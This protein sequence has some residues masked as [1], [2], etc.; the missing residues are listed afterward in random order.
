M[1]RIGLL[2]LVCIGL[3]PAQDAPASAADLA[4]LV[5]EG[6]LLFAEFDDLGGVSDWMKNTSLGR[7]CSEPDVQ[8]FLKPFVDQIHSALDKIPANANPLAA[9]G[10]SW[11]DFQGIEIRRAGMA[12][13]DVQIP[14]GGMNA[15]PPKVDLVLSLGFRTGGNKA[16]EIT[17]KLHA[18]IQKRTGVAFVAT[19]VSGKTVYRAEQKG[20]EVFAYLDAQRF[21]ITMSRSRMEQTLDGLAGKSAG[22]SLAASA[23]FQKVIRQMGAERRGLLVYLDA[24]RVMALAKPHLPPEGLEAIRAMKI[25]ALEA[26][27]MADIPTGSRMRTEF[28]ISV[29]EPGGVWDLWKTYPIRHRFLK[30]APEDA[31]LYGGESV[32]LTEYFANFQ[33]MMPAEVQEEMH[34]Q[35]LW[36]V[37]DEIAG[38]DVQADVLGSIGRE[39]GW[40]VSA[41]PGGGL[42]PDVLLF[43]EVKER[44]RL[45]TAL[46]TMMQRVTRW[47]EKNEAHARVRETIY[48]TARIRYLELFTDWEPVG[49]APAWSFGTD[50]LVMSLYPHSIKNAWV[51]KPSLGENEAFRSLMRHVPKGAGS[52]SYVDLRRLFGWAYN[53]LVPLAQAMQGFVNKEA[54]KVGLRLNLEDLPPAEPILKHL[55]GAV[56]YSVSNDDGVRF[57]YVS[58]FGASLVAAPVM[59]IGMLTVLMLPRAQVGPPPPIEGTQ[60]MLEDEKRRRDAANQH[61][62]GR[63]NR[64]GEDSPQKRMDDLE[65]EIER[66]REE[67]EE[68]G[69]ASGDG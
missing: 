15:G 21:L 3:A 37:L 66:I 26:I 2:L 69:T 13:V 10:L 22:P 33:K 23:R 29:R 30:F 43:C 11:R 51:K 60:R 17:E 45:E 50:Y 46:N 53:T 39:W 7:I 44:A 19:N 67:I 58:D 40:Y 52:V 32:D 57:G 27:A 61:G 14:Q 56:F 49:V 18:A 9:A 1:R 28:A 41:P 8:A 63:G 36:R 6:T 65:S 31:L 59:A 16:M 4:S 34:L 35:E 12:I 64:D 54:A 5:P 42:I 55:G 48:R 20:I 62:D 38:V 68:R 25:D 47:A 24:P